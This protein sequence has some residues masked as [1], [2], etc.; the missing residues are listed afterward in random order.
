MMLNLPERVLATS[1]GAPDVE[2]TAN[3]RLAGVLLSFHHAF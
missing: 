1:T 2:Q 3:N